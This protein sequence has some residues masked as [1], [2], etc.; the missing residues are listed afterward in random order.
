[1][2]AIK[3]VLDNQELSLEIIVNNKT[4]DSG[5]KVLQLETAVG[6]AIKHFKGSHGV[7]VPRR[8]FLPVKSTSDLFLLTSDLYRLNQGVIEMNPLRVFGTVPLVKLGDHFQ[9][10]FFC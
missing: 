2:K 4:S 3:R 10:V 1:L 5:V 6:A 8:R 9:K 7:N